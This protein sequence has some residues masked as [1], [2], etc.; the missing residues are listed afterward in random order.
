MEVE[1][2]AYEY[3]PD[4][5]LA[6]TRY[7]FE[8]S[9]ERGWTVFHAGRPW[10]ALGE[11]YRLLRTA[12]CGVC[13]TDLARRYLPFPLPQITGHEVVALDESGAR[14][15]VDINASAAARGVDDGC[16]FCRLMP[17]HCPDRLVLGIHDLPGGFGR[18]ILAPVHAL[19]RIPDEIDDDAAVLI[20]P[21]A[22]ALHA[23]DTVAPAEGQRIGVL[24]PRKL[25]MLVVAALAARRRQHGPDFRIVAM[26]RRQALLD[27][28]A[29]A[30]A[31]EQVLVAGDEASPA[32]SDVVIDCTG[33]P[34]GL[35][36]AL[37]AARLEV[38]LKSTHGRPAAGLRR[39]TE[40]VVDELSIRRFEAN[41]LPPALERSRPL[42]AWLSKGQPAPELAV[43]TDVRVATSPAALLN[44]LEATPP[45]DGLPRADA[46][47][48]DSVRG[49]ESVIRP[50]EDRETSLVRPRGAI[51]LAG[52][53]QEE[54]GRSPLLEAV[55]DRGLRLTSSRCGDFDEAIR[56]LVADAELR[57]VAGLL[58][59]GRF[60]VE[61]TPEAFQAA[62]GRDAIKAVV[63]HE[64]TS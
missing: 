24:G 39:L 44:R 12:R 61:K 63:E 1:F 27:V 22:A 40:L 23:V 47:V 25:G 11:G 2:Q 55:W 51:L 31:D 16:P 7:R 37:G 58:I 48:V 5:S 18:Y 34:A 49:V 41:D 59:T 62:A 9:T 52:P 20:E 4:G 64:T 45:T 35:E 29:K 28:A 43:H 42:I 14:Y 38:H 53:G 32:P 56:L 36:L 6:Q 46:A 26:A 57:A 30:G 54:L 17:Q 15:A 60:P 3:Q 10:V 13:S 33:S 8:G 19:H 21:L 50:S